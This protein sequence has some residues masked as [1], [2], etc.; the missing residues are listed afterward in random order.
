[1]LVEQLREHGEVVE[2]N[3]VRVAAQELRHAERH[4]LRRGCLASAHEVGVGNDGEHHRVVMPVVRAF[5]LHDV[6]ATGRGARDADRAHRRFG[7]RVGEAN[8][9]EIEA[10][11]QLFGEQH[12]VFGGH[13]E[14]R[15]G[16]DRA[17]DRLADL[18][19][20]VADDHRTEAA[21]RVDV[22]VAVDVPHVGAAALRGD[23]SG[24]DRRP[25]TTTRHRAASTSARVDTA[26][27]TPGSSR[28]AARARPPRSRGRGR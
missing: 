17:H 25:G 20:R 24:T 28:S 9:L 10:P 13:R 21:V 5:D 23:R 18:R 26:R 14:V 27:A 12:G 15:S 8:L 2:R 19:V 7:A 1:M 4:R 16:F 6:V 22:L 11:A 3:R